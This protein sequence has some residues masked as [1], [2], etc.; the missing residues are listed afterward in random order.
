M[1]HPHVTLARIE[2]TAGEPVPTF[3][4][5]VAPFAG[6]DCGVSQ[7]REVILYESRNQPDGVD[8]IPRAR[9]PLDTRA[10]QRTEQGDR[11]GPSGE[12]R[13]EGIDPAPKS[14]LPS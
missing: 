5:L 3:E 10:R 14:D 4:Q 6:R 2:E 11:T 13:G 7:V 12:P 8:Y 9:I 1:F